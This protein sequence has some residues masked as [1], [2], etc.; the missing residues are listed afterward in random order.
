M[1]DRLIRLA[2]ARSALR[3][4]RYEE[5]LKLT[6]DPLLRS[7]R[8][9]VELAERALDGLL[10]RARQRA[11]RGGRSAALS[12]VH[13][14]LAAA[15]EFAGAGDLRT[16]LERDIAEARK[17][18]EAARELLREA[19]RLAEEG[20]LD[21]AQRQW[22]A[23]GKVHELAAEAEAAKQ[24]IE[25][26]REAALALLAQAREAQRGGDHVAARDALHRARGQWRDLPDAGQLGERI[27]EGRAKDVL[28]RLRN[29]HQQ[30]DDAAAH[31][32][33][34]RERAL[35]PEIE[36]VASLRELCSDTSAARAAELRELLER[37]E[38]D[39]AAELQRATRCAPAEPAH[40]PL[41][42]AMLEVER[43]LELR[44]RGDFH[45]AAACLR[46]ALTHVPAAGLRRTAESLEREARRVETAHAEA[47]ERAANGF[48]VE[49][50]QRLTAVLQDWPM[51]E[52]VRAELAILDAGA[53]N[54]GERLV[55]AR[56]LASEGRLREASA[57]VLSLA[58]AGPA[59]DEARLLL[60]E[61]Q[62]RMDLVQRGIGQVTRDVHGRHSGSAGGLRHCLLRIEQL[63]QVQKDS[64]ELAALRKA[65]AAEIE[66]LEL[67]HDVAE[68]VA[69]GRLEG[70][71]E[72]LGSLAQL[73]ERLLR[74]DRLD[75]RSLEVADAIA[76]RAEEHLASGRLSGAR[77]WLAALAVVAAR[78]PEVRERADHIA[79]E[80]ESRVRRAEAAARRGEAA[81]AARDVA[82]AEASLRE[83]QDAWVDGG[84][85][86]RLETALR[87][88]H[89]QR[90]ALAEVEELTS[91][92]DYAQAHR[93]LGRLPPT[94][95]LLRTRIFDI[96]QGLARAQGLDGGFLLRVDEGGEYLV[97]R[98]DRIAIGN[99]RDGTAD[100][101]VLANIA[102]C[103]AVLTRSMSFH[104]GMQDVLRAEKGPLFVAG[105]SVAEVK[106]RS[107][108]RVRL[109][110][111]LELL[112]RVP[113]S[114]SLSAGLTLCGGFQVEGTDKIILMRDRGRDGRILIGP[115]AD[116]HVRLP[117][118]HPE[119]ELF[120]SKDGQVRVRFEG[121]GSLG[122]RPF[123]GEHPVVAGS[124][125]TCGKV[126]FVLQPWSRAH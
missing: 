56:Q 8:R 76:A 45:G 111:A 109:G 82:A 34:G 86:Q 112:Y 49:A 115:A 62:A 2:E 63:E 47:R 100:V 88:L 58:E 42:A 7:H 96:K 26:R 116:A 21:A 117:G 84:P 65:V 125:V 32:L 33:L 30:G 64:E 10:A 54:R 25:A 99:V 120:A 61:V 104:G 40:T 95:P 71:G 4:G 15:P 72:R 87:V 44:D 6:G 43:G 98:G 12:D 93:R 105:Q 18:E 121:E 27:A 106:L 77:G 103:H 85:V 14:V 70:I 122:G 113:S 1:F 46:A 35:L 29:L 108:D 24:L 101:P 73:Q 36:A 123:R 80:V 57:Q 5:V 20:D 37:G 13:R 75:A 22:A 55:Q 19:R 23:A 118:D 91:K 48:L 38:L 78:H 59:G 110:T 39:R 92:R 69:A 102:G 31:A 107:G 94:P 17:A 53:R 9:A 41:G 66:G 83:A 16:E 119:I 52:A 50:R 97:L 81:L 90:L 68:A 79:R 89:A 3:K 28:P 124:V 126:S 114:R 67:L 11:D 60:K 51:H 74:P